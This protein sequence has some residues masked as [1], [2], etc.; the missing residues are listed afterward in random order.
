MAI[1]V[2]GNVLD[3]LGNVLEVAAETF[4][5]R[6]GKQEHGEEKRP[7][8][9]IEG[10][11][12]QKTEGGEEE[13]PEYHPCWGRTIRMKTNPRMKTKK[14]KNHAEREVREKGGE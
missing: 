11:G 5:Q 14:Q 6:C 12:S 8:N 13:E 1:R 4:G 9:P 10:C 7:D 3:D 2:V